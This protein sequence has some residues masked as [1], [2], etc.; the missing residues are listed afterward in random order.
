MTS[1]A[2]GQRLITKENKGYLPLTACILLL[3]CVL[4]QGMASAE[5]PLEYLAEETLS[6]FKPLKGRVLA[7]NG[8]N[9]NTDLGIKAGLKKGMRLAILR[10][11]TAFLHPVTKEP[12]GR[13]EASIGAAVV[14]EAGPDSSSMEAIKGEAGKGD[15]VRISEVKLRVMFYQDKN[16]D[17]SIA[18]SYYGLLKESGR[19]ELI[20][21]PLDSGDDGAVLAEAKKSGAHIA[22]LLRSEAVGKEAI[23]KQRLLWVDDSSK[24]ADINIRI[25]DAF[26][27]D[28]KFGD[29]VVSVQ[30][31]A[32]LSFSL[33]SGARLIATGDIDGDG[34]Q[35]L[36]LNIGRE[37]G[38]YVPG[39]TLHKLY[40]IK[41][42]FG[43]DYIWLDTLDLN[44][45]GRDEVIVTSLRNEEIVSSIYE[46]KGQELALLLKTG[47]FLRKM[48][49]A[50][51][52]QEY[53]MNEGFSGPA[54]GVVYKNGEL[55]RL[56]ALKI[57]NNVNIYDFVQL[58]GQDNAKNTLAYDNA[59]F[60][61]LYNS[62]GLRIW[63]SSENYGGFPAVFKKS[64]SA[65][66][67]GEWSVKN[68]LILRNRQPLAIK[69]TPFIEMAKGL[70]YKSSQVRVLSWTGLS[71][72]ERALISDIPGSLI[73]Y[74]VA[75]DKLVVITKPLFGIKPQNI[76]KG[77]SPMNSMLYIYSIKGR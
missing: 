34:R 14:T 37:I 48:N 53:N 4:L 45:D 60:L 32:L 3:I 42:S 55:K 77:E 69:K 51:I 58:E 76:L 6:Y 67:K 25:A 63:Q 40:E 29:G 26:V 72:D 23:L 44:A 47:L 61:N 18:D 57:P 28:I 22:L 38:V 39:V 64:S 8:N 24:L 59:G 36:I 30:G 33:S 19:V 7:V 71:I 20:D 50:L 16:V 74:A 12:I 54:F 35:E 1:Q 49:E 15:I 62:T 52:A 73:D 27:K 13:A 11:G 70:G 10:E 65:A 75:G 41:G 9:I 68:R 2:I 17:W 46:L 21:T 56:E 43:D 66:D 31:E 5:D